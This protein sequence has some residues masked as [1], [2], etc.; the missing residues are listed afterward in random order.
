M[1]YR[2]NALP[3]IK[4]TKVKRVEIIKCNLSIFNLHCAAIQVKVIFTNRQARID[5]AAWP[6][7]L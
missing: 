1:F 4:L 6:N 3:F 2:N 5:S 7:Y